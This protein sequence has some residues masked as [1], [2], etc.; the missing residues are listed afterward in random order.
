VTKTAVRSNR[1]QPRWPFVSTD[2]TS[3]SVLSSAL[4]YRSAAGLVSN[5]NPT[6]DAMST[7]AELPAESCKT[8]DTLGVYRGNAWVINDK[9][10]TLTKVGQFK[11]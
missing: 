2:G 6:T 8:P 5:F 3:V 9:S 11:W 7:A 1:R 10:G 4:P